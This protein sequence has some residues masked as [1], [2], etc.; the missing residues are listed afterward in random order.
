MD[1]ISIGIDVG[2]DGF[3]TY[4][5]SNTQ[6]HT[7]VEIPKIG[8]YVDLGALNNIFKGLMLNANMHGMFVHACLEDVHAIYGSAAGATFSFGFVAGATEMALIANNVPFT[9]VMPKKWQGE[10]WAG[11]PVQLK[12]SSTGKTMVKDTKLMSKIAAT[13]LFP[14]KDLRRTPRCKTTDENLI[15]SLLICEY[16][17]RNF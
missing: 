2:K 12:L 13:R 16:C 10:M 9:K 3:I 15:D 6:Q 1:K 11:I 4:Y 5:Y 8:K 7:H 17:R 14:D